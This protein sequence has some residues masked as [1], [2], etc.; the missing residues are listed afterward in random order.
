MKEQ[1]T[2]VYDFKAYNE[3]IR[4][5]LKTK[6]TLTME[7][8]CGQRYIGS[9]MK[10]GKK[11]VLHGVPGN[12]LGCYMDGGEIEV[13]GNAQDAI[14]NTMNDGKIVVHGHAGD[15]TG[16]AMRGGQIIIRDNAGCRIGIHMKEYMDK[17]PEIVIG[18]HTGDFLGEYMA[19]GTVLVLGLDGAEHSGRF[20]GTGMHGGK[21]FIRGKLDKSLVANKLEIV[22]AD[23]ADMKVITRLVKQYCKLFGCNEKDI[24]DAPFTKIYALDKRP[25]GNMYIGH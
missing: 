16:Y 17:I 23:E 2:K 12:D 25:Y 20:L 9:A 13:V 7:D 8:V 22:P 3:K 21:I 15:T 5:G 24:M 14:G 11:L 4:E 6:S 10:A 18:G 19:G 1:E